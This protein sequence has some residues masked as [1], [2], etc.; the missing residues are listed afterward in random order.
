LLPVRCPK[1]EQPASETDKALW[2][3]SARRGTNYHSYG[4]A[5]NWI[6]N[7]VARVNR[8]ELVCGCVSQLALRLAES[9]VLQVGSVSR[10]DDSIRLSAAC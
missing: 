10:K 2:S 5:G 9:W 3:E 7:A 6:A 1:A 4:G 8:W